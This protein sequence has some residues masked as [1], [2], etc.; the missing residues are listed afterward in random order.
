MKQLKVAL[1]GNPNSGKTTLFNALTGARQHVGNWPGVT[2]EKKEGQLTYKDTQIEVVDLPGIY[3][4]S[5]SSIEEI[6]TRNFI[7]DEKP[8]VILNILDGTTLERGLYLTAQL[9]DMKTKLVV[10]VNMMD[11]AEKKGIKIDFDQMSEL[12][13]AAALPIVAKR[14]SG[15][16]EIL[17]RILLTVSETHDKPVKVDYGKDIEDALHTLECAVRCDGELMKRFNSRW[18]A[19]AALEEDPEAFKSLKSEERYKDFFETAHKLHLQLESIYADELIIEMSDKRYGFVSGIVR[20]CV[21]LQK[22][23]YNKKDITES[24]DKVLLNRFLSFPMFALILWFIFQMTFLV[25]GFFSGL[26]DS[27]VGVFSNWLGSIMETGILKDLVINGVVSGVGGVIVFLPQILIL[28]LLIALMEDS[29]YMAR[30]AFIMDKLMH[31]L[32]V[33]GKAFISLFMGMGCNVPGIMAARTLENEDDRKVA[34]LINPFMSCSA[35]LPVYVLIAGIF[36]KQSAGNVIFLLYFIGVLVAVLSAKLLKVFFFKK[37]SVPFVMELPPYRAPSF[38]SLMI[39]MWDKSSQFLRKMGGVILVGSVLIWLLGYFPRTESFSPKVTLMQSQLTNA[40]VQ[41]DAKV[42]V[43]L[44]NEIQRLKMTEQI[45]NSYIGSMG[46]AV[47][48]FFKPLGFGWREGV[49]LITGVIA[50]EIVVSTI[51]V[52]YGAADEDTETLGVQMKLAGANAASAFAFLVFVLLYVPC[53]ATIA[54]VWQ[55]TNSLKWTLFSV[56]YGIGI[57]YVFS[58]A[59]YLVGRLIFQV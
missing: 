22:R 33:H 57:A 43:S 40:T 6:V 8:D 5:P 56:F 47:E 24:I 30:V 51:S 55:E 41:S 17:E 49:A 14:E 25:G 2:V 29:G 11:E 23:N 27:G 52:L 1:V 54:A 34:I 15:I 28:F 32:G 37:K 12:L 31:F 7:I 58:F 21:T 53:I 19:I 48:P 20:E 9:I 3:S 50:K 4:L 45:E 59:S 44:T 10:A 35:R 42:A 39:H 26:I 13:D 16:E 38:K 18:L 46:K 36:F